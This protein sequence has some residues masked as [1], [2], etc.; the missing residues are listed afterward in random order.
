[1][2]LPVQSAIDVLYGSRDAQRA[3]PGLR[4]R[5]HDVQALLAEDLGWVEQGL[6][7]LS[8]QGV[9]P[10][11]DAAQHLVRRGGKRIRPLTMLLSSACF[12]KIPPS[13][14]RV[15][16]VT[17]LLHSATLLH[18]DVADEGMVRRGVV[19]SRLL[20][21]NAVSVLSGDLL[22]VH[23]LAQ[24]LDH[25]PEIMPDLVTTLRELVDGEVLQLRG[26]T[27]LDLSEETYE[28]ILRGKTASLF[29]FA[30][31][32]GAR[33]AGAREEACDALAAFGLAL[34][35]AFQLVDDVLDYS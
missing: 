23:A 10:A 5:L 27:A 31:R 33:L 9:S 19:T 22:L 14:R 8:E 25:A 15:A 1:M 6:A 21:G 29:V 4:R 34:G 32:S 7:D 13:V 3:D 2:T 17:E 30:A 16:M 28:R 26:R 18:D 35:M 20:W 12:G 24:T 11:T